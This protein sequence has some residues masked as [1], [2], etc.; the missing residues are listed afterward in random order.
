M[1]IAR[2]FVLLSQFILLLNAFGHLSGGT[3]F[4]E[5]FFVQGQGVSLTWGLTSLAPLPAFGDL[6]LREA[7]ALLTMAAPTPGDTV[8][9][10]AA[11]L[12]LWVINLLIPS[13]VGIVWHWNATRNSSRT[14]T[15]L[16]V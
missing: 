1:S 5:R 7:A 8:A 6:G 2:F 13:C 9:I 14:H 11:T 3:H 12:T 15:K 4:V 10:V 16:H